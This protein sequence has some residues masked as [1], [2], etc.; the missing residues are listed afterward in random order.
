MKQVVLL[1]NK[2]DKLYIDFST[3]EKCLQ[4]Y[5]RFKGHFRIDQEKRFKE[6]FKSKF[7]ENFDLRFQS[8]V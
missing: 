1:D 2:G 6:L 3:K 7:K 8:K 5:N 4:C